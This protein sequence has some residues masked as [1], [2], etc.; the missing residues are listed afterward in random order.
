LFLKALNNL[1]NNKKSLFFN[2]IYIK[3]KLLQKNAKI[4][5]KKKDKNTFNKTIFDK[6][7]NFFLKRKK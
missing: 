4:N 7:L 3:I 1:I 6:K 2:K 5:F